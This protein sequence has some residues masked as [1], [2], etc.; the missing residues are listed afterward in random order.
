MN[1]E[2]SRGE[3][4][5]KTNSIWM[6][7]LNNEYNSNKSMYKDIENLKLKRVTNDELNAF[8]ELDFEAAYIYYLMN[9][10]F[11]Y[12]EKVIKNKDVTTINFDEIIQ[13]N[14]DK[15]FNNSSMLQGR[16]IY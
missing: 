3:R 7:R 9:K 14:Y 8:T 6:N 11:S 15:N 4:R 16:E 2:T 10:G 12:S 5:K 13:K 1:K